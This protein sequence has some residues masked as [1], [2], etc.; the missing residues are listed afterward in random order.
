MSY[1]NVYGDYYGEGPRDNSYVPKPQISQLSD[2]DCQFWLDIAIE[3]G[4]EMPIEPSVKV[5]CMSHS[6]VSIILRHYGVDENE[7]KQILAYWEGRDKS[8]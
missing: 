2:E 1:K 3:A 6:R 7:I 8:A 4:M 5:G